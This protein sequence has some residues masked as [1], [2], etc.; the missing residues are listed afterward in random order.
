VNDAAGVTKEFPTLRAGN[1][2]TL[3][4]VVDRVDALFDEVKDRAR[5]VMP[6]KHQFYGMREFAVVD[7]DGYLVTF[8]QPITQ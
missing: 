8:A 4:I 2:S 7:P 6:L 5:I 3:F 1:T